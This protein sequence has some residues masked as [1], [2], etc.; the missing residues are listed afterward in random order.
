LSHDRRPFLIA[1]IVAC[2]FFMD[3]LD[4]TVIATALPQMARSFHDT[5]VN[6]SIGM[7]A[8]LLTLAVFIPVSGWIADRFGA[9]TIF[10][11]AVLI[12]T[13]ASVLCGF[14]GSL[15][16]FVA[17]R[18]VQGVG[19]AMMVPVGRLVVLR[20][21]EKTELV[22]AMAFI[23]TPGLV[24]TVV[25]PPLGGFITTF[26]TWRWIFFLNIPIGIAGLILIA[27]FM[28]NPKTDVPRAFDPLGFVLSG[29]GLASLVYG[30]GLVGR[31]EASWSQAA[32]F[33]TVGLAVAIAA[34]YH[35]L[36]SPAPLL[37]LSTLRVRTFA[38]STL[39]CGVLYRI[40]I[41]STPFLW[42]LM[43]Q[44]SFGMSAFASGLII[45]GCAVGDV[46]MKAVTT[47]IL[48]RFGF[49]QVLFV[50]GLAI[51]LL[52]TLSGMFAR[53]TPV[54]II[55]LVLLCV[56]VSRSMQFTALNALAYSDIEPAKMGAASS[57][58]STL[59]QISFGLG[60]AFAA[61]ALHLTRD[62]RSSFLAVGA[63]ALL[64]TLPSLRLDPRAGSAVSGHLA[65][66]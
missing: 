59:Q 29:T 35:A 30:I 32:I 15:W 2:A 9:R 12:F 17:A 1:L 21:A 11:S 36:R 38:T 33:C 57:L 27:L 8:Y 31:P 24:A 47:R 40:V 49:R 48:R 61:L 63:V 7:T 44:I 43:F 4:G 52:V 37:D 50:N 62:F 53:T 19:G 64:S 65:R 3:Q 13:L 14:S 34:V 41:G 60:I 25:G 66:S 58:A 23:T 20:T 5:P 54:A 18:I 55:F 28:P 46:S 45:I 39:W 26:A 10:G 42:P 22:R 51:A 6:V 16:Q 56:G